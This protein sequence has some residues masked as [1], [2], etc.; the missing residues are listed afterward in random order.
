M[1]TSCYSIRSKDCDIVSEE[2][3]VTR[4]TKMINYTVFRVAETMA[5]GSISTGTLCVTETLLQPNLIKKL[6]TGLSV[7][8]QNF[9]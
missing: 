9:Y 5:D 3:F 4:P 1:A 7:C 6:H 2:T 8:S